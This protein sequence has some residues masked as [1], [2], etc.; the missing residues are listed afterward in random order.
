M[1]GGGCIVNCCECSRARGWGDN[2]IAITHNWKCCITLNWYDIIVLNGCCCC[3][4]LWHSV[5][6]L[7]VGRSCLFGSHTLSLINPLNATV[8]S[9]WNVQN[10]RRRPNVRYY[11]DSFLVSAILSI[12]DHV[13]HIYDGIELDSIAIII[14][15]ISSHCRVEVGE[16]AEECS[17]EPI[18][19]EINKIHYRSQR[20]KKLF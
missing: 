19:L 7:R 2:K 16:E 8:I 11:Y 5:C 13:V 14:I 10:K 4:R 18:L 20:V 6:I 9:I 15:I 3:I 1:H 17:V 12:A